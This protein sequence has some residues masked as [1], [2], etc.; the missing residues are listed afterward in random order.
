MRVGTNAI[1]ELC[2]LRVVRL[3]VV[4]PFV[5]ELVHFYG[6]VGLIDLDFGLMV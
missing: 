4:V 2:L 1:G 6:E 3:C 5:C